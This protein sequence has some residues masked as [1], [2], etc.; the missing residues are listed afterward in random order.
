M[1]RGCFSNLV[2]LNLFQTEIG[3]E[4][5][6]IHLPTSQTQLDLFLVVWAEPALTLTWQCS[7]PWNQREPF[8]PSWRL[9]HLPQA[10]PWPP[11]SGLFCP[12]SRFG[13]NYYLEKGKALSWRL[14]IP[15]QSPGRSRRVS[16]LCADLLMILPSSTQI[17]LVLS[18]L[19]SFIWV[20]G[21]VIPHF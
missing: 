19:L 12:S 18:N 1:W 8:C 9:G 7:R 10:W 6:P 11:A 13:S 16:L 14:S 5:H 4:R 2:K 15:L 21:A 20:R 17:Q 3:H